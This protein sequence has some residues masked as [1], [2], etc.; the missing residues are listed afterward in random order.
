MDFRGVTIGEVTEIRV[1]YDPQKVSARIPVIMEL[2]P[3]RIEITADRASR[4]N[5]KT[6][7]V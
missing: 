3:T 4:R 7:S 5:R 6:S 2:D 1:L